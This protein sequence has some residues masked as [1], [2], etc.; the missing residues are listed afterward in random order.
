MKSRFLF[1]PLFV[2]PLA[3]TA[4]PALAQSYSVTA[5]ASAFGSGESHTGPTFAS[6]KG[7]FND[8]MFSGD[9]T[10]P[11][12]TSADVSV[13]GQQGL[14]TGY[15][16]SSTYNFASSSASARVNW[17]DSFIVASTSLSFGAPIQLSFLASYQSTSQTGI[18]NPLQGGYPSATSSVDFETQATDASIGVSVPLIFKN[19]FHPSVYAYALQTANMDVHA[20]LD[21]TVGATVNLTSFVDVET[22]D[23]AGNFTPFKVRTFANASISSAVFINA[24][25]GVSLISASGH[26]YAA[27]PAPASLPVFAVGIGALFLG[28]RRRA[29]VGR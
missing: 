10:Y 4:P 8:S 26:S 19:T 3:L 9:P 17:T 23:A 15:A 5:T 29:F 13:T 18:D 25:D 24:P 2:L 21:T 12:V 14:I 11:N 20:T 1:A 22:S 6:A 27:T 16:G 28:L 7:S